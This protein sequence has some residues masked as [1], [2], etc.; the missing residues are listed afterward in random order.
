MEASSTR[1]IFDV[2]G[3][4]FGPA[5]IAL[6]IALQE[7]RDPLSVL[8]LEKSS[9]PGWQAA[10]LLDGS[11]IQNSALRDLVTPRNPR[12]R[13]SFTNFLFEQGR[14]FEYL[15]LGL[16]FPLRKEYAQY[17]SWVARQFDG[18]VCYREE[19]RHLSIAGTGGSACFS[20]TT[21]GGRTFLARS[22]VAAPGRTPL[23]PE[24]FRGTEGERVFHFTQYAPMLKKL[25]L[26]TGEGKRAGVV[27]GSQSAVEII[28]DLASRYPEIEIVNVQRGFGFSLKDTSPF[29]DHVYFP[30]HVDYY[31]NASQKSKASIDAQLRHTNYLS[32][33]GD[34][35]RQ[36]YL[37][38]YEQK[39]DGRERIQVL[40]NTKVSG[41][42]KGED[43]LVIQVEEIHQGQLASVELD[44]AVLATGFR[45]LGPA[46]NQELVPPL[47]LPVEGY[48]SKSPQGVL[49]IS[50]DYRLLAANPEDPL[51][52]LYLN[53]LCETTHGMGDAG[54][55]SLLSLRSEL[56]ARSVSDALTDCSLVGSSPLGS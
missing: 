8:F 23:I 12:S 39:L 31:F 7:R 49:E 21:A 43:G 15:N 4:G 42:K 17:V 2:V 1:P 9:E 22:L 3:I 20:I 6:A 56:I 41:V 44:F 28:L 51:P 19:V 5:N 33:D 38:I 45:N 34:V 35:I 16:E 27:G 55:F 52:P 29:S 37:A 32:A 40:N 13:Y 48:L 53:G 18:Q 26:G 14:L 50:R 24:V 36:L 10:M 47:L 54:S 46:E 11:D 30:E 25:K